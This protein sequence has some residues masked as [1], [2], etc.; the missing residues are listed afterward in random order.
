MIK[1]SAQYKQLN[2]QKNIIEADYETAI[3]EIVERLDQIP[4]VLLSS[5]YEYPGRYKRWDL[6]FFNPPIMITST[7]YAAQIKALNA[8]GKIMM[9]PIVERLKSWDFIKTYSVTDDTIDTTIKQTTKH[10]PEHERSR[11]PSIFSLLR[12]LIE[13]FNLDEIDELSGLYGAFGYNLAFQFE[14]LKRKSNKISDQRDLVL[15]IP[16]RLLV[17]DHY[18]KQA[19]WHEYEF[20]VDGKTTTGL[21]RTVQNQP[22]I[23]TNEGKIQRD[24]QPGDYAKMV[25]S[26]KKYFKTGDLFEVVPGQEFSEPLTTKPSAVFLKLKYSNPAPY[27]FFMNLCDGEFLVGASP[28]MFVRVNGRRVETCPISGTVKRIGN[29]IADEKQILKL[30]QSEK[31][32]S[33]LTMCTDVDRNDKSRICEPGS[34]NVI[35]RRQIEMYSRVIHTVDHVEGRLKPEFDALDAFLSHAWAVTVTGAPKKWAMQFIE[36]N[37]RS[38]RRWYGGAV[39][40]LFFNGDMN[41]G[42]T[43]RTIHIKNGIASVRAG[44]TLLYD[45]DPQAEEEETLLKASAFL[46]AIKDS[47]I[48]NAVKNQAS[49]SIKEK[50]IRV[51]L[52]DHEDSFVHTLANYFQQAGAH[53]ITHRFGF[54]NTLY[55]DFKPDLVVL[56]PGPGKPSDFNLSSTIDDCLKRNLPIFGVCLGMQGLA[57]YF[58][59]ELNILGIPVHG[60]PSNINTT[61]TR[62]FNGMPKQFTVGRYHSL[63]MNA[64]SRPPSLRITAS[65]TDDVPMAIEHTSLPIMAVQFHPESILSLD[66]DCGMKLINNVV[67]MAQQ[68]EKFALNKTRPIRLKS[69]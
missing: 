1:Q 22:F 52:I 30:L 47:K 4:G 35:G 34:V 55:S 68:A 27:S 61:D 14:P 10:F 26:A 48:P 12:A 49:N 65:T 2:V 67:K 20:I 19:T 8:R 53:V 11:Q 50:S 57:E 3:D 64:K 54:D 32:A 58:G 33:E 38:P 31:E 5:N 37:E 15:Y 60:K 28:E 43:L 69:A 51:L 9:G 59:A 46:D 45:S 23:P 18:L 29:A 21:T 62:L 25:K 63:Y 42:L 13:L 17:V 6:G 7:N 16:D 66:Q 56:S 24:H 44:A 40:A 41:T 39:G 36:D